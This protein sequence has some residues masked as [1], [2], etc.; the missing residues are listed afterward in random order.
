MAWAERKHETSTATETLKKAEKVGF[1]GGLIVYVAS[2]IPIALAITALSGG[3]YLLT[4]ALE[5]K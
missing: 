2:G 5:K 4:D 3:G 1:W